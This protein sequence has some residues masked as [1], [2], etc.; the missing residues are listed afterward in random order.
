MAK[1][2]KNAFIATIIAVFSFLLIT[3]IMG[4]EIINERN[5][6]DKITVIL[7]DE[8][9]KKLE[10]RTVELESG[11]NTF[12]LI[13]ENYYV[14]YDEF[15]FGVFI[16]KLGPL[17]PGQSQY[18][19]IYINDVASVVGIADIELNNGDVIEFRIEGF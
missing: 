5:D 9:E 17:E 8:D 16:T 18:I 6:F 1:K 13:V 3:N 15:S 7:T 14:E 4:S 19:A 10:E 12:E 2:Y 11:L